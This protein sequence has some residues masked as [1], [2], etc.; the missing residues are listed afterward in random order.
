M[1]KASGTS[2]GRRRLLTKM[3][4]A[5]AAV[6]F[7]VVVLPTPAM[8]CNDCGNTCTGDCMNHCGGDCLGG[9]SD[10]CQNT[11]KDLCLG[12]NQKNSG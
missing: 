9:C 10:T 12:N 2:T 8:A 11:C 7:A 4:P 1:T 6:G 3:L 5:L